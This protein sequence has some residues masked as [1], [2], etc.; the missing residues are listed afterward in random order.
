MIIL[1]DYFMNEALK[2]AQQAANEGEVPIGAVMVSGTQILAKTFNQV[3]KL[4]DATAHAEM[5]AITAGTESMGSKYLPDCTLYITL[6]PCPMCAAAIAWAQIGRIVFAAKDTKKGY[7]LF[8]PSL[9]H[10]RTEVTNGIMAEESTKLMK[11]FFL[12]LR[13]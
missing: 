5:L 2:L 11:G 1:D 7:S 9:L 10:P 12:K 4:K 6:E 3:K 13:E 8:T